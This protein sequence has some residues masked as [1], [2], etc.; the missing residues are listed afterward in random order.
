[1]QNKT[2]IYLFPI[3]LCLFEFTAY[4]ANDFIMPGMMAVVSEFNTDPKYIP[5]ALACYIFGG[6]FLQVILGPISDRY[7]RRSCLLIGV[8]FFIFCTVIVGI[9]N[10]IYLFLIARFFQGSAISFIY[11]TGYAAIQELFEEK[12]AIRIVSLMWS[13]CIIAPLL[14]PLAGGFIIEYYNWRMIFLIIFILSIISFVGL[15]KTMLETV[16]L[17]FSE[18]SKPEKKPD[19]S[20]LPPL[21]FKKAFINYKIILKNRKFVCGAIGSG[22]RLV[23]VL[24]WIGIAPMALYS[25]SEMTPVKFGLLQIPIFL[26]IIIGNLL[27]QYLTNK[28]KLKNIIYLG[29]FTMMT[30]LLTGIILSYFFPHSYWPLILSIAIHCFGTGISGAPMERLV[31]FS[32]PVDKGATYA[33]VSL[34]GWGLTS[35]ATAAMA[36]VFNN[37]NLIFSFFCLISGII[38]C[39][40]LICFFKNKVEHLIS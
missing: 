9:S 21:N 24:C 33:I 12:K 11:V 32:T 16:H 22:L 37:S 39:F 8:L 10:S 19:L 2:Q 28:T 25:Y 23:P 6:S 7:G 30:G 14:G 26:M 27:L 35:V 4:I 20:S 36:Y 34:I 17:K 1:M 40:F 38:S 29:Y 3:F 5:L 18:N 31:V 15:K 13:I